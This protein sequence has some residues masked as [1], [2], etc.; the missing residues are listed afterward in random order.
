MS[1]DLSTELI[2]ALVF[3]QGL[4][5]RALV[6]AHPDKPTVREAFLHYVNSYTDAHIEH[7]KP[8]DAERNERHRRMIRM[9]A[10]QML[11]D[12]F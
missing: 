11:D 9:H 4:M 3:A 8:H 7:G 6:A 1:D 2:H 12:L 5:L 10:D